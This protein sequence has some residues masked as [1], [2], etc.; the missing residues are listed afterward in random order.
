MKR[1]DQNTRADLLVSEYQ[2]IRISKYQS[3]LTCGR[4]TKCSDCPS[5][6]VSAWKTKNNCEIWKPGD[7]NLGAIREELEV[8]VK[9]LQLL[10]LLPLLQELLHQAG[11]RVAMVVKPIQC[12][13]GVKVP[14]IGLSKQFANH[15][16]KNQIEFWREKTSFPT[17]STITLGLRAVS[18]WTQRA[19]EMRRRQEEGDPENIW[20]ISAKKRSNS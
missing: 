17:S 9:V 5:E 18:I 6:A 12:R 8:V 20:Q 4:S 16:K 7:S 19:D 14:L 11:A 3:S 15:L 1:L 2:N 13:G 10:L